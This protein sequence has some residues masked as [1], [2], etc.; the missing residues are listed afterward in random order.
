[1]RIRPAALADVEAMGEL[2]L[3]ASLA[4]GDHSEA[5]ASLPDA[6]TFPAE[7]LQFAFVA[8][9]AGRIAGFATVLPAGER[10]A[11]LEDLFVEPAHW[12]C[13]V[14]RRLMGEAGRRAEAAGADTLRVIANGRAL[15]FYAACGFEVVGE[16]QTLLEP[17][18]VMQKRLGPG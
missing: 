4:W 16:T 2:K 3:R 8:E 6:R 5:L 18:L 15:G 7:H 17:A 11:E 12:R 1:M 13:G 10:W 9:D 14:G